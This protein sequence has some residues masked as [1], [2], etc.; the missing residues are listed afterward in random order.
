M[1]NP[2]QTFSS[3]WQLY[4]KTFCDNIS[5][6]F[7]HHKSLKRTS[8]I[9]RRKINKDYWWT[10]DFTCQLPPKIFKIVFKDF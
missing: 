5:D 4:H 9:L 7:V 8:K 6:C 2:S 3:T 10:E 1:M